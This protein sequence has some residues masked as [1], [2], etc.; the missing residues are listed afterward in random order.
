[1]GIDTE[2]TNAPCVFCGHPNGFLRLDW[3]HG[4]YYACDGC[5]QPVGKNPSV[6]ALTPYA[7]RVLL[8]RIEAL[9]SA[10]SSTRENVAHH[11]QWIGGLEAMV[12]DDPEDGKD[13]DGELEHE[14]IVVNVNGLS[15]RPVPIRVPGKPGYFVRLEFYNYVAEL[16]NRWYDKAMDD[17]D[18]DGELNVRGSEIKIELDK[19]ER[20]IDELQSS[21]SELSFKAGQMNR[22]LHAAHLKLRAWRNSPRINFILPG[23][24]VDEGGQYNGWYAK[25][26]DG[27]EG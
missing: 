19:T 20:R 5:V 12:S 25:V 10:L 21:Y 26:P 24:G 6:H 8:R 3:D 15:T 23:V 16:W 1:M 2:K 9:E 22:E 11:E 4:N 27:E 7:G 13:C 18:C 17:K 14:K